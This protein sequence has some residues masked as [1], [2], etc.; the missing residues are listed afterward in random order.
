MT[1]GYIGIDIGKKGAIVYQHPD[2]KVEAYAIPMIKDEVDYAFMYDIIQHMNARHYELYDC[3]PHMILRN[4][5]SSSVVLK[6]LHSLW[7]TNLVQ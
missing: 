4:W 7:V 2:G 1:K 5:E 3:H 6:L